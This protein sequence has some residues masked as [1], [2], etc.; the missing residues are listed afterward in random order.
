MEKYASILYRKSASG[1]HRQFKVQ[2]VLVGATG[3]GK[4]KTIRHCFGHNGDLNDLRTS[5]L[6][7]ETSETVEF[8]IEP[9]CKVNKDSLA[10]KVR[11]SVVD[12][13][14][15]GDTRK[16]GLEQD[17]R[18]LAS[19]SK[20][21]QENC[22]ELPNL[23]LLV[24]KADG[25]RDLDEDSLFAK[26]LKIYFD[27]DMRLTEDGSNVIV[28]LTHALSITP[29]DQ[30]WPSAAQQR[31]EDVQTFVQKRTGWKLPVVI[32]ENKPEGSSRVKWS[33]EYSR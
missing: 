22:G 1:G 16:H 23:V 3:A 25:N 31:M 33:K 12:T 4:T 27:R 29:N 28:V 21:M 8:L 2:F 19:I 6:G 10:N 32:L 30:E 9:T 26:S 15:F 14:G 17:A 5:N 24:L 11:L 13:P 18:N 20:F 7:S